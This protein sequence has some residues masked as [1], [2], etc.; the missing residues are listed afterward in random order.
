MSWDR[1]VEGMHFKWEFLFTNQ[2]M[3]IFEALSGDHNPIHNDVDFAKSKGFDHPI[4]YGCLL[5]SQIS[6]LI[7]Q[8]LPDNHAIL[9]G[10]KMDFLKPGFPN[11]KLLFDAELTMKSDATYA[12]EFKC[13]ITSSNKTITRGSATAIWRP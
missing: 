5:S 11:E 10:I 8:E 6:R 7:G 3:Q 12:L 13:C 2:D 4:I 9:A 1:Y